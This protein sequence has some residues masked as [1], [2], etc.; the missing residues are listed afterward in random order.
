MIQKNVRNWM[1][2]RNWS[3]WRLFVKV[4]PLLNVAAAEDEMKIKEAE[5]AKQAE[6]FEKMQKGQKELEDQAIKYLQAKNDMTILLQTE[7]DALCEAEEKIELMIEQK[8]R[9][10]LST[11][12]VVKTD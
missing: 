9:L 8:V 3:W 5:M 11:I 7:Q 2:L 1:G 4:K 12:G 6:E 10:T